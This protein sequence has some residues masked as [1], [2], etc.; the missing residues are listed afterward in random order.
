[1]SSPRQALHASA[2]YD[3]ANHGGANL[4][5]TATPRRNGS[6]QSFGQPISSV[7][8]AILN[9]RSNLVIGESPRVW[10][11]EISKTPGSATPQAKHEK[12]QPY[13]S[14]LSTRKEERSS[15]VG[16][17]P[18]ESDPKTRTMEGTG[19]ADGSSSCRKAPESGMR[20]FPSCRSSQ[21]L[22]SPA[23]ANFAAYL[24][25]PDPLSSRTSHNVV[26]TM[27]ARQDLWV[28]KWVDY[29]SKYGVGYMLS[30]GSIGVYFNDSTKVIVSP[31]GD[32]FD[33]ITRRTQERPEVRTNHS[34][35]DYPEDL[36]KKVTLLRHF[37][38]YMLTDRFERKDGASVGESVLQKPCPAGEKDAEI[39]VTYEPGNAPYVKKWIRNRHAMMF[40]L[41]SKDIHV[42]FFDKTET[43]ISFKTRL[44]TYIDKRSQASSYPLSSV[45]DVPNMELA[46]RLKYIN[47]ILVNVLGARASDLGGA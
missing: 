39:D 16:A 5:N 43:V 1:M 3:A 6:Q 44:V 2:R 40:Q 10:C 42:I 18:I 46:R 17:L 21:S 35:E 30:D 11:D 20:A 29:S 36:K 47:E 13:V 38:S 4:E 7:G 33:Y 28:T 32:R 23:G 14:V 15:S 9:R 34:I 24:S 27:L 25:G 12:R 26:Q 41:S 37:T 22:N 31:Q 8:P 45:Q 19:S